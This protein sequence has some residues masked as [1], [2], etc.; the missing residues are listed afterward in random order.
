[1]KVLHIVAGSLNGGAAKGA[2][3]LHQGLR[4]LG[5]NS[6][7]LNSGAPSSQVEASFTITN[8]PLKKLW[9]R[10]QRRIGLLPLFFYRNRL[11]RDFDTGIG[12]VD[13]TVLPEYH[14]S[15]IL[16]LHYINGVVPIHILRKI[17]KPIVWTIRDMWPFTGG[18]HYSMGCQ[19]YEA[20]C[21]ECPQL[22]SSCSY[23]ISRMILYRKKSSIQSNVVVVGISKWISE[24]ARKSNLFRNNPVHTI[25]N[26]VNI[27]SF[28][29]ID[30]K[31]A[32]KQLKLPGLQK[33]IILAGAYSLTDFYKGFDLLLEALQHLRDKE[34]LVCL[35][36]KINQEA[37][38]AIKL[39]NVSFGYIS[40][41][42]YLS[43]VY[44]AADVFV[45]PSRQE[46]FGKTLVESLACGTPVVCFDATG[47]KDIIDHKLTGYKA[48]AFRPFDLA[49]GIEW[50]LGL[51]ADQY[52]RMRS[53]CRKAAVAR[54]DA[55]VIARQ[56]QD[57]YKK[58][59]I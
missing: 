33:R 5:V 41:D 2:L 57:L 45:A 10:L 3:S 47:P 1:M 29:A 24:C 48:E 37:I 46:A 13:I 14:S 30:I 6:I 27:K 12:G 42:K 49:K 56:Y 15:D 26:N 9:L 58:M 23:D 35:F 16:H 44:S 7:L 25:S 51:P 8:T 50:I 55:V 28:Q 31:I 17:E 4:E 54:F 39:P 19:K 38:S 40:D 34:I 52:Q 11:R 36:G 32:R 18:C 21:G 53:E 22:Q 43:A 20:H 59:L